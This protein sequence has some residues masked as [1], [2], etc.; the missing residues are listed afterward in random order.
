MTTKRNQP[1]SIQK[2]GKLP[3]IVLVPDKTYVDDTDHLIVTDAIV[4]VAPV[5]HRNLLNKMTNQE[6]VSKVRIEG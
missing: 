1:K 5:S 6:G 4:I 2:L 3:P